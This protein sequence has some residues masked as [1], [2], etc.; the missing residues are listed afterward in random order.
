M[1]TVGGRT[2]RVASL[3]RSLSTTWFN[4]FWNG[5]GGGAPL[6]VE[7]LPSKPSTSIA[8]H[9]SLNWRTLSASSSPSTGPSCG[10]DPRA[11]CCI[12][13][14]CISLA[15]SFANSL[16]SSSSPNSSRIGRASARVLFRGRVGMV[17]VVAVGGGAAGGETRRAGD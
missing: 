8:S 15:S 12:N 17:V 10:T 16:E 1:G 14:V 3:S 7:V 2:S 4:R 9:A 5:F 6:V 11:S 13:R